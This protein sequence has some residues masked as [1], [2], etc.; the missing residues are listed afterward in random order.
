MSTTEAEAAVVLL[1]VDIQ[2]E[3]IS[4]E[5][6]AN[7]C[8]SGSDEFKWPRI[9]EVVCIGK[10]AWCRRAKGGQTCRKMF[11]TISIRNRNVKGNTAG[12]VQFG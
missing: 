6:D 4:N 7:A 10:Y 3:F 9:A 5:S 8:N 1:L 2:F 12:S 11:V